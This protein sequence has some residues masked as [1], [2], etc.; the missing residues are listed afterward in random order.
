MAAD[1]EKEQ[2]L[3]LH[4]TTILTANSQRFEDELCDLLRIPSV[5]ADSQ[6]KADVRRAGQ[7]VLKQ[8]ESL[9]LKAEL[10]ETA[11]HPL[12]YAES[13]P[14]ARRAYGAGVRPLRRAAPRS[15][16]P[17]DFSAVRADAPRREYLRPRGHR[18]QRP[19]AHAR[20]EHRSM[21]QDRRQAARAIEVFDRRRR[22]GR[23][24]ES[25]RIYLGEPQEDCNATSP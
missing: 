19:N 6:H 17:M 3:C 16:E 8:F 22:R 5:S 21:A 13:P 9:G 4:S 24:R 18:R 10:I 11:G 20:E 2:L 15:A 1:H 14:V 12:V 25:V 7:W 23:Q